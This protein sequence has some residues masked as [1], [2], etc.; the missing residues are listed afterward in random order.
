MALYLFADA[1]SAGRPISLFN[2]GNMRR[3][4]TYVDDVEESL[5]RLVDRAPQSNPDWSGDKPDPS[6][7]KA[8]WRIYN[9]GNNKP[10][11]LKHVVELLEKGLGRTAEKRLLPMQPGDV[12]EIFADVSDLQRDIDFRPKTRIEDGVPRFVEWYRAFHRV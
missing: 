6:S 5:V 11:E 8:P 9:I 2:N 12:P 10:E 4:F 1:I 3:D 7:S